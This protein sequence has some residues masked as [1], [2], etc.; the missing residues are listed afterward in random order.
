MKKLALILY[1]IIFVF[2]I[3]SISFAQGV[4]SRRI[5]E[6]TEIEEQNSS[7][8]EEELQEEFP[9][10]SYTEGQVVF[11][12]NVI[13]TT[14][15]GRVEILFSPKVVIRIDKNSK[16]GLGRLHLYQGSAYVEVEEGTIKVYTS[17]NNKSFVLG[18]GTH[19][20]DIKNRVK[21]F[22]SSRP[23]DRFGSWNL[24]RQQQMQVRVRKQDYRRPAL[25]FWSWYG[26]AGHGQ[27]RSLRLYWRHRL[28]YRYTN[29]FRYFWLR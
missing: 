19:R 24:K 2:S 8:Q 3:Y 4:S 16:I 23:I 27:V 11:R 14:K 13:T 18:E 20:L 22:G 6:E 15:D 7:G 26:W 25:P 9:A 28:L 10:I 1:V 5:L 29:Y 21:Y 17:P 12:G